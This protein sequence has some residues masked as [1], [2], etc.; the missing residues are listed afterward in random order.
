LKTGGNNAEESMGIVILLAPKS[1]M[2]SLK[3]KWI[4]TLATPIFKSYDE[5]YIFNPLLTLGGV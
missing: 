3:C 1:A 2:T 5:F 4:V